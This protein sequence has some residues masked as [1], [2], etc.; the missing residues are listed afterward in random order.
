MVAV[1][2][3]IL[4]DIAGSQYEEYRPDNLDWEKCQLFTDQCQFT[5]D[6]VMTLAIKKA[7]TSS[8]SFSIS[9]QSIGR[10]FPYCGWGKKFFFWIF[11]KDPIPYNSY[12]NGSAMRVS[13]I[14]EHFTTLHQV[15]N[16]AKRSAQVSH[17]HPEGIKGAVVTAS[18]VWMAKNHYSKD[19]IMNYVISQYPQYTYEFSG[20]D[21]EYLRHNYSW[22]VTCMS[23]VPVA[24]TCF[25]YSNSYESF[26]RNVFSLKC[27]MDTIC[28]IGG[29]VAEEYY[30]TTGLN[31]DQLLKKY[32][33][34]R[35][36]G[37]VYE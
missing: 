8:I 30:G 14:G 18:C 22:D 6:T 28:A 4:G 17:N 15:Q 25:Y 10:L 13:Y 31:T 7:I 5:D 27:D 26:L 36:L 37:I 16:V 24:I 1:I 29:G 3:S 2:G 32:L 12:G 23:C 35:L 9:M 34:E 20:R 11:C 19:E 33:D 21:M